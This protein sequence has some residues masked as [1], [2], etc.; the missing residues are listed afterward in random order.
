MTLSDGLNYAEAQASVRSI[1]AQAI[2]RTPAAQTLAQSLL[3]RCAISIF[4][5]ID[6]ITLPDTGLVERLGW[7][8]LG[9]AWQAPHPLL[10]TV[11]ASPSP[12][13][14]LRVEALEEFLDAIGSGAPIHGTPFGPCRTA[15]FISENEISFC[16]VERVGWR[17]PE[18]ATISARL[19]RRARIHQQIFRTRRRQ[20]QNIERALTYT[21]RLAQAAAADIG[22]QWAGALFAKAEREY[23]QAKSALAALQH[24]RQREAGVGWCTNTSLAYASSRE[25]LPILTLILETLGYRQRA[26]LVRRNDTSDWAALPFKPPPGAPLILVNFDF[27][28]HEIVEEVV[29]GSASPL[30]WLGRPGIWCALHGESIL[31]AGLQGI[32]AHYDDARAQRLMTND[33]AQRDQPRAVKHPIHDHLTHCEHRAVSPGRTGALEREGYLPPLQTETYR[34]LGA[35]ASFFA[36]TPNSGGDLQGSLSLFTPDIGIWPSIIETEKPKRRRRLRRREQSTR[37]LVSLL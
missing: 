2:E 27:G 34:L 13:I 14:G 10:P 22:P 18:P 31:D 6:H 26:D 35:G 37:R 8:Y 28:S 9:G 7:T 17:S 1:V 33:I 29:R 16:A 20:F 5:M 30:T 19:I 23:W 25:N 4:D 36:I 21:L 11:I 15:T 12:Q 24:R 32:S 3:D